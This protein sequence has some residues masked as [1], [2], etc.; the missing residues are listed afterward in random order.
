M[1]VYTMQ[2]SVQFND[3]NTENQLTMKGALRLMQEASNCHSDQV[4]YGLN[5]IPQ[6]GYSWVLHQQ[7]CHLDRRPGWG[8]RLTIRTWSRGAEGLICLRDFEMLDEQG[9]R[10]AIATTAWLLI[11][12]KAQK[13]IKVPAGMM[14]EYGTVEDAV[15]G[16]P[17][18]RLKML[19]DAEK[20]WE[21]TI[22]KRDID[23]NR[24]VNN[25]CYLDYALESLPAGV[26]ETD[27]RDVSVMYK[28]AAYLG[29]QIACYGDWEP[30]EGEEPV[31][32]V[33]AVKDITGQHL[34]AVI[35]LEK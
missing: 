24:H 5:Q 25:L 34:H 9:Q 22:L 32:Y 31:S 2:T 8:T 18:K 17:M 21:Y 3:V 11:D 6:T 28:K 4:G 15:F 20:T 10:V 12:A 14:D 16:E 19:K 30:S 27:F 7:R 1:G 29:D 13:M 23:I 33:T 35:R 26:E